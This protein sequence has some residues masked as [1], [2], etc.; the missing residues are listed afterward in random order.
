MKSTNLTQRSLIIY[1]R[2]LLLSPAAPF[3]VFE[4]V[5]VTYAG[6]S[7]LSSVFAIYVEPAQV[8]VFYRDVP[9]KDI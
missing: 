6:W 7:Q 2:I 9:V 8:E 3:H 4:I 1:E 5:F